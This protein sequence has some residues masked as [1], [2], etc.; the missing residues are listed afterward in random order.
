MCVWGGHFSGKEVCGNG[1]GP[2]ALALE[3]LGGLRDTLA[4]VD[5]VVEYDAVLACSC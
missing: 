5:H 1:Q 3:L 2:D 4:A